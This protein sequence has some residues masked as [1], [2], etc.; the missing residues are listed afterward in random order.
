[1]LFKIMEEPNRTRCSR[2]RAYSS[3]YT[4]NPCSPG[5]PVLEADE[6]GPALMLVRR[7]TASHRNR[8]T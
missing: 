6:T 2:C 7:T 4:K 1:M 5:V 8:K 3:K